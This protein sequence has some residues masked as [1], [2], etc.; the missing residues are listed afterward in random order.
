MSDTDKWS[1]SLAD[2][3]KREWPFQKTYLE[4]SKKVGVGNGPGRENGMS[5][6]ADLSKHRVPSRNKQTHL[7]VGKGQVL[8]KG[9]VTMEKRSAARLWGSLE[10]QSKYLL[11]GPRSSF[12]VFHRCY[13]RTQ[14]NYLTNPIFWNALNRKVQEGFCWREDLV[15]EMESPSPPSTWP[16]GGVQ[17]WY[18]YRRKLRNQFTW[19]GWHQVAE[20]ETKQG[21][22]QEECNTDSISLQVRLIGFA[23]QS[24]GASYGKVGKLPNSLSGQVQTPTAI[25]Y[26]LVMYLHKLV[27]HHGFHFSCFYCGHKNS[28]C[29]ILG[30]LQTKWVVHRKLLFL[31]VLMTK[32]TFQSL[33]ET[34]ADQAWLFYKLWRLI[35]LNKRILLPK[36]L[37]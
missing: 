32:V 7:A 22:E 27:S 14:T 10:G 20:A 23:L 5:K 34:K 28:I 1:A 31:S 37:E 33:A 15:R 24:H 4:W 18:Q 6:A 3:I 36:E 21:Q 2:G 16:V 12:G 19:Q 8:R 17:D 29:L 11:H 30:V 35:R 9:K 25:D 26:L 13:G